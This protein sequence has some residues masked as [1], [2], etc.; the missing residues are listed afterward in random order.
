MESEEARGPGL[1]G[2]GETSSRQGEENYGTRIEVGVG[3]QK[4]TKMTSLPCVVRHPRL[5]AVGEDR[6]EDRKKGFGRR[7]RN[8]NMTEPLGQPITP[9]AEAG[10]CQVPRQPGCHSEVLT[11]MKERRGGQRRKRMHWRKGT[12]REVALIYPNASL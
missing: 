9:E 10:G 11:Q 7:E 12:P 5:A 3:G 6:T 8:Q 1:P 4:M 2:S